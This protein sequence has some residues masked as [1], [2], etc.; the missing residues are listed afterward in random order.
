F[1]LRSKDETAKYFSKHLTEIACR[2]VEVARSDRGGEYSKGAF[3]AL[4]TTEKIRQ[5]FTTADSPQYNGVAD[6]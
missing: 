3:G 4:C 1:F 5:E 2:K 6:R